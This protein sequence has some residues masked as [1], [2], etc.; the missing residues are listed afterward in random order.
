MKYTQKVHIPYKL[1]EV[2]HFI[3][4]LHLSFSK[5]NHYPNTID[6]MFII[7]MYIMCKIYALINGSYV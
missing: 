2:S 7:Y 3:T 5:S 4:S 6:F 1:S